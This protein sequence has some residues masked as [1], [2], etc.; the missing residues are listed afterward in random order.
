MPYRDP[1][2]GI[3][4]WE[5]QQGKTE[6]LT[7]KAPHTAV[8]KCP[9]KNRF[10]SSTYPRAV[11]YENRGHFG[12]A[13]REN[14]G[15]FGRQ[16]Y[17]TYNLPLVARRYLCKTLPQGEAKRGQYGIRLTAD[18]LNGVRP[19]AASQLSHAN[20]LR[21]IFPN[22]PTLA[23]RGDRQRLRRPSLRYGPSGD[24]KPRLRAAP[25]LDRDEGMIPCAS[26]AGSNKGIER[27]K[28]RHL[29]DRA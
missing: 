16:T 29:P 1:G 3:R 23:R 15:H 11:W 26:G 14:H 27:K 24:G 18:A 13:T 19:L 8:C 20:G 12:M 21:P 2:E 6:C 22:L 25:G 28:G 10:A 4:E 7:R 9:W 17:M 5:R